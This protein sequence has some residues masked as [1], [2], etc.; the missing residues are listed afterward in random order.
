MG[1]K[2]LQ[3]ILRTRVGMAIVLAVVALGPAGFGAWNALNL[4]L[5]YGGYASGGALQGLDLH[6]P[7]PTA[8][9]RMSP[10]CRGRDASPAPAS[11]GRRRTGSQIDGARPHRG[12][13]LC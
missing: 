9:G 2:S 6:L 10:P 13:P 4:I 1:G 3:E 7:A 8:R 11:A 5:D 12:R